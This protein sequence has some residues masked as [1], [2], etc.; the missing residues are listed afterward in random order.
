MRSTCSTTYI[1]T[2]T[3]L[4]FLWNTGVFEYNLPID[5]A[6]ATTVLLLLLVYYI[7]IYYIYI[8]YISLYP[9]FMQDDLLHLQAKCC[10]RW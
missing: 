6:T 5:I 10:N 2:C 1:I 4:L 9:S 8:I 3:V 7:H